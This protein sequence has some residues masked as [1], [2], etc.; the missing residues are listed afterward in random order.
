MHF[1]NE[2]ECI[3]N[4]FLRKLKGIITA[5]RACVFRGACEVF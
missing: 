3:N 4:S 2:C 5:I 1:S